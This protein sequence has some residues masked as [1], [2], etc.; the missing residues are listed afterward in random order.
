M[1]IF[2][3]GA[4]A[5]GTPRRAGQ[6]AAAA[7]LLL[8]ACAS[9]ALQLPPPSASLTE[10]APPFLAAAQGPRGVRGDVV[11]DQIDMGYAIQRSQMM[12][13][14]EQ[15][16]QV[17]AP[18]T[19]APPP[20]PAAPIVL[21]KAQPQAAP[22]RRTRPVFVAQIASLRSLEAAKAEWLRASRHARALLS[23]RTVVVRPA[24]APP[25]RF[26]LIV[27]DFKDGAAARSFCGSL[28]RRHLSCLVR[29]HREAV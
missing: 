28:R 16:A 5:G 8:S 3:F 7:A 20:R 4:G 19:A 18:S 29:H 23:A 25:G 13:L 6:A 17:P 15:R 26:H 2:G 21:A 27:T 24:D 22:A 11:V 12:R 14:A 9:P 10:A 1:F